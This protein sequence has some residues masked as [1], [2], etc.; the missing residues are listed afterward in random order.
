MS[1]KSPPSAAHGGSLMGHETSAI[2]ERLQEVE[3]DDEALVFFFS[4]FLGFI[5]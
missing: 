2:G 4:F 1:L 5:L 3:E